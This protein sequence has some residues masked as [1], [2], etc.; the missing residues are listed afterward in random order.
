MHSINSI[1]GYVCWRLMQ[2]LILNQN[3]NLTEKWGCSFLWTCT[4]GKSSN[5]LTLPA[6]PKSWTLHGTSYAATEVTWLEVRCC[7]S[8][9]PKHQVFH[10]QLP[11]AV[12]FFMPSPVSATATCLWAGKCSSS[13]SSTYALCPWRRELKFL[14]RFT[15]W[16][17]MSLTTQGTGSSSEDTQKEITINDH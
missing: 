7:L 10:S 8:A 2:L 11:H 16:G 15:R 5:L 9:P 13:P 12:A 3:I 17:L 1:P 4:T 14:F 6:F